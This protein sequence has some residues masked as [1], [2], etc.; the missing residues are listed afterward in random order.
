MLTS[1]MPPPEASGGAAGLTFTSSRNFE[2]RRHDVIYVIN[3]KTAAFPTTHR[4]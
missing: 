2:V 1:P 4:S 3:I